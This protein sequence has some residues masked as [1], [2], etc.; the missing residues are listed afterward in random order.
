V[1]Q[2]TKSP[3]LSGLFA[4]WDLKNL[5]ACPCFLCGAA[6]FT[7]GVRLAGDGVMEIAIAGKP[8]SCK[9]WMNALVFMWSSA[10]CA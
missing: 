9:Y 8:D 6:Y 7:V 3:L 4:V 2:K 10:C 1:H 5:P